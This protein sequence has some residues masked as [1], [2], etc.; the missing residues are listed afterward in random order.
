[1][2]TIS[3]IIKLS[4]YAS[5]ITIFR[6]SVTSNSY[7]LITIFIP[8]IMLK[9]NYNQVF[10]NGCVSRKAR[11]LQYWNYYIHIR[12]YLVLNFSYVFAWH[13]LSTIQNVN[14]KINRAT[15][16]NYV[17]CLSVDDNAAKNFNSL[18][19]SLSILHN[20]FDDSI[21]LFSDLYLTK[22]LDTSAKSFFQRD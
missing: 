2:Y 13:K 3:K 19:I 4:W 15:Y 10:I 14:S 5:Y 21:K 9:K 11:A 7:F 8:W 1:M 18:T 17:K 20:Y 12:T 6:P 16:T 22:F